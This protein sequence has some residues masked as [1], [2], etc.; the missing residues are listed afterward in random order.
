[1]ID[2]SGS[3]MG[4]TVSPGIAYLESLAPWSGAFSGEWSLQLMRE[5]MSALGD[6]QDSFSS[7]HVTGT[8]GK[9]SV[10]V[11]IASILA[12][13]GRRIGLT[14]SP[15]LR[16]INERIVLDGVPI[17]DELLNRCGE[18]V[19]EA[20][21]GLR[22]PPTF[23]EGITAAS[24]VAFREFGVD[25]AVV[26]VG[27]GGRLDATNVIK[28]PKACVVV[29]VDFDHEAILGSTLGA[30]AREKAG[31]IKPDA[32]VVVGDLSAEACSEVSAVA[33]S[34]NAE[35]LLF[36]RDFKVLV[37]VGGGCRYVEGE[38]EF[39]FTP[40]LRGQHQAHNM[41]V[42]IAAARLVGA[43]DAECARGVRNV[44]WPGRLE[45]GDFKGREVIVDAAHNPAG[46]ASLVTFLKARGIRP[47]CAFGAI[48]TKNWRGMVE[49]LVPFVGEWIVLEPDFPKA[50][51]KEDI[52]AF[53][54]RFG[55]NARC[56]GRE[57]GAF[58]E[59]ISHGHGPVLIAGSIYLIGII[60][61]LVLSGGLPLWRPV[62][63]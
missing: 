7:I 48:D 5:L 52:V 50:V 36:G 51:P 6:P 1:M 49:S 46:V 55:I 32:P 2:S 4:K 21:R 27:L 12:E 19:R 43:S 23:F 62:G 15:H 11:A 56:F 57:Y 24:F 31:I 8:N 17:A 53:L 28:S 54:S 44:Y 10:S 37:G 25:L 38:A 26:E 18:L 35:L 41:A 22:E 30:I 9:G 45:I 14:T 20:A 16:R 60:R 58:I 13:G 59:D 39:D 40:A 61:D 29:T 47:V 42:A 63:R 3:S 34:Q 33:T